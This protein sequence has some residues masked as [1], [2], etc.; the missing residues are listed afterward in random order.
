[1][2]R[3]PTLEPICPL[4]PFAPP[5]WVSNLQNEPTCT[6]VNPLRIGSGLGLSVGWMQPTRVIKL[7]KQSENVRLICICRDIAIWKPTALVSFKRNW[8]VFARHGFFS[9]C[10]SEFAGPGWT[11][12]VNQT[13]IPIHSLLVPSK[14]L[15]QPSI[16]SSRRCLFTA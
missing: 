10:R 7:K 8:P 12:Y 5:A 4:C 2:V 9:I 3:V 6:G 1:M 11:T 13:C 15:C 16:S 14:P